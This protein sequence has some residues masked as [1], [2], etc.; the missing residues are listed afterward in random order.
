MLWIN[1][2]SGEVEIG[3]SPGFPASPVSTS[4]WETLYRITRWGLA[5]WLSSCS[6]PEFILGPTSQ[7]GKS[8]PLKLFSELH[9][10]TVALVC[11]Y[12][13]I[14]KHI[15]KCNKRILKIKIKMQGIWS[16]RKET[17][18]W[19]SVH[20][21]LSAHK[22]IHKTVCACVH[23]PD[24][25]IKKRSWQTPTCDSPPPLCSVCV[26]VPPCFHL[27]LDPL[28]D[29]IPGLPFF[30]MILHLSLPCSVGVS[31]EPGYANWPGPVF[32]VSAVWAA[33]GHT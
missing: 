1:A 33:L 28:T 5:R 16:L 23:P 11:L 9:T 12:A 18:C 32:L 21:Y 27:P 14:N 2:S 22:H 3:E 19:I 30:Q 7:K 29:W 20:L 8:K 4:P 17:W 26:F 13:P 6:W 24:T 25:C 10:F 15:N 31:H